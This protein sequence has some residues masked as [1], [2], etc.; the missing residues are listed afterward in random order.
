MPVYGSIDTA[1]YL[2]NWYRSCLGFDS[3]YNALF[4][5]GRPRAA[6]G[7]SLYLPQA[8]SNSYYLR[9]A[10]Y[11]SIGSNID[12][13]VLNATGY[14]GT[15]YEPESIEDCASICGSLPDCAAFTTVVKAPLL[16]SVNNIRIP[17]ICN[18]KSAFEDVGPTIAMQGYTVDLYLPFKGGFCPPGSY[19]VPPM[20]LCEYSFN[21]TT[22]VALPLCGAGEHWDKHLSACLACLPGTYS[23]PKFLSS[24]NNFSEYTS[25]CLPCTAGSVS[26]AYGS[27][28][29]TACSPGYYSTVATSTCFPVDQGVHVSPVYAIA[30]N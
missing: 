5:V 7:V 19:N 30:T 4:A 25:E 3:S 21:S 13:A 10:G 26:N 28:K 24:M 16:N 2:C 12:L 1:E 20:R 6:P 8:T 14:N 17:L 27:L 22:S 29:C 11:D 15:A 9:L 18:F 23:S